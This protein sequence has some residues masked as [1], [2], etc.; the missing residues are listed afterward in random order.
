MITHLVDSDWTIDY[1]NGRTTA[2]ERLN[3]LAKD[4]ALATSAIVVGEVLEGAAKNPAAQ[5]R[6]ESFLEGVDVVEVDYE[7]AKVY[8]K[9]RS[10]L[11]ASGQ[12][13]SDNDLWIA[14]TA[15]HQD[16]VLLTRDKAFDRI[17]GLKLLG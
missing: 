1:L 14:A 11:R 10:V 12:L 8:G 17:V 7:V 3:D 15:I 6:Y 4:A 9:L 13:M 5:A 16:L 2:V